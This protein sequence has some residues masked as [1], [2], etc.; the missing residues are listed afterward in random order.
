MVEVHN[1]PSQVVV[2]RTPLSMIHQGIQGKEESSGRWLSQEANIE[3][4]EGKPNKTKKNTNK[5]THITDNEECRE[6]NV[7]ML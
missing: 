3:T 7:S 1:C 6:L 4:R 2:K 5:A